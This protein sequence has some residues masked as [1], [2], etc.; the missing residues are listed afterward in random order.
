MNIENLFSKDTSFV[1]ITWP[2]KFPNLLLKVENDFW[3]QISNSQS[4]VFGKVLHS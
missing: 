1:D 3:N 4:M 2:A